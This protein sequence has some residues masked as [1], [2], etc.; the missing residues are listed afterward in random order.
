MGGKQYGFPILRSVAAYDDVLD[1]TA[2]A[3]GSAD[4]S[5]LALRGVAQPPELLDDA[6]ADL[7]GGD[8]SLRMGNGASQD[9]SEDILRPP[10]GKSIES[11][12]GRRG[13]GRAH[14]EESARSDSQRERDAGELPTADSAAFFR[15]ESRMLTRPWA[16][17]K[18]EFA[19]RGGIRGDPET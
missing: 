16:A 1:L 2:D 8:A 9:S 18:R 11:R 19:E 6:I 12:S 5:L 10:G 3:M 7:T 15:H 17:A 14:P 13:R 4:E